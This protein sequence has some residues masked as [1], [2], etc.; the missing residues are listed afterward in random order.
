MDNMSEGEAVCKFLSMCKLCGVTIIEKTALYKERVAKVSEVL[1]NQ[2]GKFLIP[3][4]ADVS[5]A[6]DEVITFD[7]TS[8][9]E[10]FERLLVDGRNYKFHDVINVVYDEETCSHASPRS[11]ARVPG[12]QC[13][14]ACDDQDF[15]SVGRVHGDGSRQPPRPWQTRRSARQASQSGG[16]R[17]VAALHQ[18]QLSLFHNSVPSYHIHGAKAI[19]GAE[20]YGYSAATECVDGMTGFHYCTASKQYQAHT[21][22]SHATFTAQ[23]RTHPSMKADTQFADWSLRSML[24]MQQLIDAPIIPIF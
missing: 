18:N 1:R 22:A 16:D 8:M 5:R 3:L 24:S 21:P 23:C 14:Q 11:S 10:Y 4:D 7:F 19:N 6:E 9:A 2:P 15:L 13:L 17:P 20:A 12:S